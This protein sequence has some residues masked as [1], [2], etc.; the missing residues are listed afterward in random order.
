MRKKIFF[1]LIV[2][3]GFCCDL[4][5]ESVENYQN[6][7]YYSQQIIDADDYIKERC[8][9]DMILPKEKENFLTVVWFHGGGL[10][11][12]DKSIPE[13][14]ADKGIAVV[15][16][17]YRLSPRVETKDCIQDAAAAVAWVLKNIETYGGDPERIYVSG[18]SAGGYLASMIGLDKQWLAGYG[19]DADGIAGLMPLSGHAITHFTRRQ[20]LGLGRTTPWVDE[21]A[22]LYHVRKEA[23]PILLI[24]GGRDVEL[25][26][27]C[28]ENEYFWRML[29][30]VGHPDVE[31]HEIKGKGHGAMV[32]PSFPI[33]VDWLV[34]HD[35]TY[36]GE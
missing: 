8:T 13:G 6:I 16:P 9:L 18:H 5:A 22:P 25:L 26:G 2:T 35:D 19:V 32:Q 20:E 11:G 36:S 10:T 24:T 7:P 4:F 23:P 12:G 28:E 34:R 27:R 3:S 33:M 21:M 31:I 29:K 1:V 15:A 14:L 30:V 17:A